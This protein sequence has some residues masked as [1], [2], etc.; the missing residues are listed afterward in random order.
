MS[1]WAWLPA[2]A[3]AAAAR[4]TAP[5]PRTTRRWQTVRVACASLKRLSNLSPASASG[6]RWT[7]TAH[8]SSVGC[9]PPVLIGHRSVAAGADLRVDLVLCQRAVAKAL[10]HPGGVEMRGQIALAGI[11]QQR[12]DGAALA[13]LAHLGGQRQHGHEVGAGRRPDAP[14]EQ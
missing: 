5:L 4:R 12:Q 6:R 7:E 1:T 9:H 3:P 13:A 11:A 8:R 14:P 2:S 10:R